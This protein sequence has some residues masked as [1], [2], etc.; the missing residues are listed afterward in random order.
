M[1]KPFDERELRT[2]IE[3]ALYKHEADRKLRASERRYAM[4][5]AS[6][7]DAV[8]ATDTAGPGH[9]SEPRG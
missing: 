5:L 6:I 9:V 1:L 3:M 8:I 2:V 4:T 7:A